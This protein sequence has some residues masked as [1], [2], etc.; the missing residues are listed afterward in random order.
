MQNPRGEN[1]EEVCKAHPDKYQEI[2]NTIN[3]MGDEWNPRLHLIIHSMVL[4]HIEQFGPAEEVFEKLMENH[5][6]HPH[7]AIHA[8]SSVFGEQI[9]AM[10]REGREFDSE[11]QEDQL[12]SLLNPKSKQHRDYVE[13]LKSGDP[14]K[15]H[16]IVFKINPERGVSQHP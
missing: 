8:L 15:V 16:V 9:F 7:S 10:L 6:L 12:K 4:G 2:S 5:N 14:P 1:Y 13:P 3:Q 11:A